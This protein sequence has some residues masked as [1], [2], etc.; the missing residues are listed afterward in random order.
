MRI[1]VYGRKS[2][3]HRKFNYYDVDSK[4]QVTPSDMYEHK[5][6]GGVVVFMESDKLTDKD[7]AIAVNN[8][9]NHWTK[10]ELISNPDCPL[11]E[12]IIENGG[13]SEYI[14]K[15]EREL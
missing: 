2:S 13:Y 14:R 6:N 8:V 4:A 3:S 10:L 7:M 9:V 15:L 11:V 1:K 5:V 12:K